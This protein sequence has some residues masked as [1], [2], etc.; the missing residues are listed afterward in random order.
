MQRQPR[1][2][3]SPSDLAA[4]DSSWGRL[5]VYGTLIEPAER[6]RLLGRE[7]ADAPAILDG[8]ERGRS[9]YFYVIRKR[10]SKVEGAILRG[11]ELRDF[12]I[13]DQYEDVPRLYTREMIEVTDDSARA[14]R[15]WIYLPSGWER[16]G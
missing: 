7:I 1:T 11:L 10:N 13:L 3:S 8:F 14:L 2:I 5:F 6:A 12:A 4:Q 15:C 9:R 16:D